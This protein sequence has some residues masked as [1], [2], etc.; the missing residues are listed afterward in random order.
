M[1]FP[2]AAKILGD[3]ERYLILR[4]RKMLARQRR[5]RALQRS[6]GSYDGQISG[7][8]RRNPDAIETFDP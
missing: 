3:F 1:L 2:S 5:G 7:S 8:E 4:S 6:N